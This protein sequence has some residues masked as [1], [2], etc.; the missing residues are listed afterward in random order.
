MRKFL[1]RV[2]MLVVVQFAY[3][4]TT[5]IDFE[6]ENSG[7]TA[8]STE[9]TT[10][11]DV[12]NRINPDPDIGGNSTNIWAV[13][14]MNL[15]SP[16]I[17]LD[18]ISISGATNFTFSIDMIAHHYNDWDSGD[19][20]LIKYSLDGG[21]SQNLMWVQ[22]NGATYN[23]TASLDSDFDGDGECDDVLPALTTGTSGCTTS[24][25]IFETFTTSEIALSS[26]STLDI[27][28]EFN[29]F[30]AT[31]EGIYLDNIV[32]TTSSS[33]VAN[34]SVFALEYATSDKISLTWTAP[35]GTYDNV[36]VFGRSGSAVDHTPSGAGSGYS[37]A[38]AGWDSAGDYDNSKLLYSGTGTNLT[39]TGLTDGTTYYF[40][41]YA[42]DDSDWSSGTS[43]INDDAEVQ[44]V[45]SLAVGSDNT[46]SE[47]TWTN[48]TGAVT[49]WWDQ[50]IVLAK[51]GSAVDATP[52]GDPSSYT[53]NAEF[54]SGS[55][56]GTGNYVV[57]KGTGTSQTVT[58][59]TNGTT[60]HY[61]AFVYYEDAGSAHD[62][63]DGT[64]ASATP[65]DTPD[66]NDVIINE[67][68]GGDSAD[69]WI[70]LL[71]V[72]SGG[73]DMRNWILTD[74]E[75]ASMG[76]PGEG[77]ISFTA[78]S[79]FS[80]I[81]QGT[82]VVVHDAAG[83]DDTDHSDGVMTL[84]TGNSL[85]SEVND[86]NL[87]SSDNLTL[88]YDD[89]GTYDGSNSIGIDHISY[90]GDVSAPSGVTWTYSSAISDDEAYFSDGTNF[91][92]DNSNLWT[93]ST[94]HTEGAV[95]TSQN[96]SS[97]PVELSV[98]KATSSQGLV[99][100]FWTTDSEIENQGFIIERSGGHLDKTWNEIASFTTNQKL[101]GQGSTTEQND[102]SFI[103][104]QVKVGKSY[105]YRLADVDYQGVMTRHEEIKVTVKDA[106]TDLKPS[107][108]KLHKAF[109]NPF[110]PDVNLSF[111][112]E[113][114]VV[115]LSLEIY[116]ITG[117]LVQTLSSG[118]HE[119]GAHSFG[120]NGY[121][122]H[123]NAV[124]SGVYMV[125]LSAGSVVQI[126]RMTL[127][128]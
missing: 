100:L 81:P 95:N 25:S 34:P 110:N 76:S 112:L 114:E 99:K 69:D 85:L 68:D 16:T 74:E 128:R 63:S 50:V 93:A 18:Q 39:V 97:L 54:S 89:D 17:T 52:S 36:L 57:F 53:A 49:T 67:F 66:P 121:D 62:Y 1:A 55:Q 90:G 117:A 111:T 79:A 14:D 80:A 104:K 26:N 10:F 28:L 102:Y 65:A 94:S 48:Y 116:D 37:D 108:V 4:A 43:D 7:Y 126:Q 6:T 106:G 41:A 35:S 59:L 88:W 44:D 73:V 70:E 87:S 58:G 23:Q 19:E 20:L 120:W 13:E 77:L 11:I 83:T 72:V 103:D 15:S 61:E 115:E 60:Y 107:D 84:Y 27:T 101:L 12:F 71:V 118:Y 96:D 75:P 123:D 22:N 64:T 21:S 82:Y 29:G 2:I 42:Y 105:S 32:I 30:E 9:G 113:N 78:N 98:W 125:R 56:V 51:S 24:S 5:T 92:N 45:T 119:T 33:S 40:K 127:L 91:N 38:N 46:Q 3:A 109:P 86:L 31:D 122:S 124:S 8:S 47:V